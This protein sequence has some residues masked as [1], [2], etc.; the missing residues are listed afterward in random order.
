MIMQTSIIYFMTKWFILF[1]PNLEYGVCAHKS[2]RYT[3][4]RVKSSV[5][6]LME[7][8]GFSREDVKA[9]IDYLYFV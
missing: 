9:M 4:L 1:I 2:I 3:L 8:L 5:D 6:I 7:I